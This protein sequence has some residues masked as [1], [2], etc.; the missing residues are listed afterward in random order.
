[1][2]WMKKAFHIV[3]G[4]NDVLMGRGKSSY[5]HIGNVRFRHMVLERSHLY[6][7][8]RFTARTRVSEEVLVLIKDRSGR[9][10]KDDGIGWVEVSDEAA[11][12]KISHA[13]RTI[14][15]LKNACGNNNNNKETGSTKPKAKRDRSP[16]KHT[17]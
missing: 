6:E 12:K 5:N 3:P 2:G 15:G 1:M 11:V 17:A 13:F 8:A 16:A 10:L 4:C 9:F 14:R 7:E